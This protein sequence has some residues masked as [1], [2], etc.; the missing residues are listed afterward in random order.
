MGP[1]TSQERVR[2]KL[3]SKTLRG[4]KFRGKSSNFKI[5]GIRRGSKVV[6]M[7]KKNSLILSELKMKLRVLVQRRRSY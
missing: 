7:R 2:C 4:V 6:F 3:I 1:V 5:G